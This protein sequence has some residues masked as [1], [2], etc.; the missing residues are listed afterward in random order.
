MEFKHKKLDNGLN[1]IAETNSAAQS[2][3]VGFFTKTGARDE[4]PEI[5]GVS[6]FLEHMMF[7]GTENLTWQ[8]VNETFDRTGAKF[9][10][11]TAEENTVY[12]AAILPEYLQQVTDLWAQLMRPSLREDDF[13]MEK[14]VIKEEIAMYQDMPQFEIF[15]H[16]RSLHFGDHPC[17]YSV[18]G[19]PKSIDD[20]SADQ[21]RDYFKHRYS[22]NNMTAV[23]SGNLDFDMICDLVESRCGNWE[24]QSAERTTE[25]YKG[26][27]KSETITKANLACQHICYVSPTV[28]M[29]DDEKYAASILSNILGDH[30]GSRLFWA[31]IDSALAED[32]S[33]HCDTMDGVGANYTYI[34]TTSKNAEKVMEIVEGIFN[35]TSKNGV[36][37]DELEAAKNKTLSAITIKNEVPMGRLI[38]LG[39]N[40]VYLE[41]Y[42]SIDK[43]VSKI[44]A[45]SLNDINN[46]LG[47]YPLNETSKMVIKPEK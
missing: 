12:Y 18:L 29:Q 39:F 35:D 43:I 17:H 38:E 33:V 5:N 31:L 21:M 30:T 26:T 22:P 13:E 4:T 47:K 46:L 15:E 20:L 7:K 41:K 8:Q 3:A 6:H 2:A 28:S 14:N 16:A 45:I 9:N 27:F 11:F 10:A 23:F 34:K 40:W 24:S 36:K 25:F 32:A 19:T 44:K 42:I 1:I 37:E